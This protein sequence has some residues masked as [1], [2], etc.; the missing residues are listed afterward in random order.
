MTAALLFWAIVSIMAGVIVYAFLCAAAAYDDSAID[1]PHEIAAMRGDER[2][3]DVLNGAEHGAHV[4]HSGE[5]N[6]GCR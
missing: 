4:I 3:S 6:H 5:Q 2:L 1:L